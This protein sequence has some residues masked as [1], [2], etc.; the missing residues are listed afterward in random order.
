MSKLSIVV[1]ALLLMFFDKKHNFHFDVK[2]KEKKKKEK[3]DPLAICPATLIQHVVH[4][5]VEK[6]I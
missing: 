3:L 2:G 1:L 4:E 5:N 6:S